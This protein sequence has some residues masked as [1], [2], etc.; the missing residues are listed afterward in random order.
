MSELAAVAL[1]DEFDA[2]FEPLRRE[3]ALAL[4]SLATTGDPEAASKVADLE[5]RSTDLLADPHRF[6]AT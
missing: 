6:A 3:H 2:S 5:R 4:W 1:L